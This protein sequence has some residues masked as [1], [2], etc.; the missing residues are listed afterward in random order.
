MKNT[1]HFRALRALLAL[2]DKTADKSA[3]HDGLTNCATIS[4]ARAALEVLENQGDALAAL[5]QIAEMTCENTGRNFDEWGE[6]ACF[7]DCVR[8]A[9]ECLASVKGRAP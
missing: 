2:A 9:S 4:K 5:E 7:T 6:A 1:E 8:I 3:T